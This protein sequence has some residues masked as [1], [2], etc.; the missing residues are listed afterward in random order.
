MCVGLGSLVIGSSDP[1][2]KALLKSLQTRTWTFF[3]EA[4]TAIGHELISGIIF[5]GKNLQ[6]QWFL[7]D[8]KQS[9]N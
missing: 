7:D 3:I 9:A 1:K 6:I 4:I 2:Q 5:K 8:F